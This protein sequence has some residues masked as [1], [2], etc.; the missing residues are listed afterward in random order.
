MQ[1]QRQKRKFISMTSMAAGREL[2][3][4]FSTPMVQAILQDHKYVTRRIVPMDGTKDRPVGYAHAII[5]NIDGVYRWVWLDYPDHPGVVVKPRYQVGD[6]LWV[7]E[8]WCFNNYYDDSDGIYFKATS[9][10]PK[11]IQPPWKPSIFLK[12]KYARIWVEVV[13]VRA[14]RLNDITPEEAIREGYPPLRDDEPG[15]L[16]G[17]QRYKLWFKALWESI[18]GKD[19]WEKNP[20]V[21]RYQFKILSKNGRPKDL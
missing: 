16:L 15:I 6:V 8:T 18:N 10:L 5:K 20:W 4:L 17:P 13:N 3:I 21:W 14:E 1:K 12:K 7:R 9:S 19:S 2:P 11:D